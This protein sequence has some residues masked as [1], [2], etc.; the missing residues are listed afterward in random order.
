MGE[1]PRTIELKVQT[2]DSS[3]MSIAMAEGTIDFDELKQGVLEHVLERPEYRSETFV[4]VTDVTALTP[5]F[6]NWKPK[7]DR[8]FKV[9]PRLQAKKGLGRVTLCIGEKQSFF[10]TDGENWKEKR[11]SS[12]LKS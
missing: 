12:F 5:L 3:L 7:G 10:F 2:T 8:I 11:G 1:T 4:D 6:P 9:A